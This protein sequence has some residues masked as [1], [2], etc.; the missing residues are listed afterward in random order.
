MA[1][2]MHLDRRF[3]RDAYLPITDESWGVARI[4]EV[5]W[6]GGSI[7]QHQQSR[8]SVFRLII[9]GCLE[10]SGARSNSPN[11]QVIAQAGD[12]VTHPTGP[13]YRLIVPPGQSC[14]LWLLALHGHAL[15]TGVQAA[16]NPAECH[17][18]LEALMA[19]AREADAHAPETCRELATL[20]INQLERPAVC[21]Y[22][23][24]PAA[25]VAARDV[26]SQRL[27]Q[28]LT[29]DE[30]AQAA[31]VNR[32]TLHRHCQRYLGCSPMAYRQR[33]RLQRAASLL[34]EGLTVSTV[35]EQ[36]GFACPFAFSKAFRRQFGV[37]PSRY[38]T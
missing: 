7:N 30:V 37:A 20:I 12:L 1:K 9:D 5:E 38:S 29:I 8:F 3:L 17:H 13:G 22:G 26:L 16:P 35:A 18:L 34:D 33:L 15:P 4:A 23:N 27:E 10:I 32:S 31:G 24:L 21:G 36:V 28:P 19:R 11:G 6:A 2:L 25:A 14:R